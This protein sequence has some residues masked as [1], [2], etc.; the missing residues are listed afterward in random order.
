MYDIYLFSGCNSIPEMEE[1][2]RILP[3][4][5]IDFLISRIQMPSPGFLGVKLDKERAIL[6]L[7]TIETYLAQGIYL[8]YS[9]STPLL[10]DN[11]ALVVGNNELQKLEI[12]SPQLHFYPP[13]VHSSYPL[14]FKV[15]IGCKEWIEDGFIPGAVV[16]FVDKIDGHIWTNEQIDEFFIDQPYSSTQ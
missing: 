2:Q 4:V 8:P 16:L 9:Y 3:D 13:R 11:K 12:E 5:D 6:F 14:W 10:D 7:K 1:I 15:V